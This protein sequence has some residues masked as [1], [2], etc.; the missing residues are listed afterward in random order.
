MLLV[1]L[2][3]GRTFAAPVALVL[4]TDPIS[5]IMATAPLGIQESEVDYV[6][7]IRRNCD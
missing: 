2:T 6:G 7:G 4:G 5:H 3:K 1:W